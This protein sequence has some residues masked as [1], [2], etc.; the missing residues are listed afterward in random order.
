M[1]V[2]FGDGSAESEAAFG[3]HQ[4]GSS[5]QILCRI[6]KDMRLWMWCSRTQKELVQAVVGVDQVQ[7]I[8]LSLQVDDKLRFL[9]IL[10]YWGVDTVQHVTGRS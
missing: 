2:F 3:S 5:R 9:M 10:P 4:V 1:L 6:I 7:C 8:V